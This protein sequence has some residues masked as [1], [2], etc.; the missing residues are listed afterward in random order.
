MKFGGEGYYMSKYEYYIDDGFF[1]GSV[2]VDDNGIISKAP[3][4]WGRYIG[5][6]FS[7]ING[8]KMKIIDEGDNEKID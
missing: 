7:L 8:T 2:E 5:K 6:S 4:C 3:P 1:C